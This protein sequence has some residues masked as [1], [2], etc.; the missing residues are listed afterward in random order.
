MK[1]LEVM[2]EHV[3]PFKTLIEVLKEI[4]P[5]TNI[6][7]RADT[8]KTKKGKDEDSAYSEDDPGAVDSD[9][10][11]TKTTK[12]DNSGMRIMA[13][14]PSKT[15]LIN[16]RL[17]GSKFQ[18][19]KLKKKKISLGV[20]LAVFFKYIKSMEKEDTLTLAY[21]KDDTN[22]L[23]INIENPSKMK[24]S[25]KKLKLLELADKPIAIPDTTFDSVV[26]MNSVEFHKT[27][28]QM[29][30]NAPYV[31][32]K[33]LHNK[34]VFS[35]RGDYG[36]EST[37][38]VDG[39]EDG[40]SIKRSDKCGK[41]KIIQGIYDLRTLVLFSKCQSLCPDIEIFMRN[42]FPLVINYSVATLGR[43]LL[44]LIPIKD[45]AGKVDSDEDDD[46]YYSDEDVNVVE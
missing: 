23:I 29:S 40:V 38:F 36:E 6:E 12:K 32:I 30:G 18:T 25:R 43:V 15:V 1:I 8:S 5:D 7:F 4:L 24:I 37:E 26:I 39:G 33:C 9:D 22:N 3:S 16:L 41:D 45:D 27:C 31:E 14:D 17:D 19:F 21:D 20:N 35:S 44:C 11:D 13:L 28:R 42:D 34:I 46:E 2:T 10:E